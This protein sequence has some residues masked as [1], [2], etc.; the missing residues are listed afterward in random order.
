MKQ[1]HS[2]IP[3]VEVNA[4][5]SILGFLAASSVQTP[6]PSSKHRW[7]LVYTILCC[8]TGVLPKVLEGHEKTK[9]CS[10]HIARCEIE[11]GYLHLLVSRGALMP[12]DGTDKIIETILKRLILLQ[13]NSI[14]DDMYFCRSHEVSFSEDK[15]LDEWESSSLRHKSADAAPIPVVLDRHFLLPELL[16]NGVEL[17]VSWTSQTRRKPVLWTQLALSISKLQELGNAYPSSKVADLTFAELFQHDER[18]GALFVREAAGAFLTAFDIVRSEFAIAAK[19]PYI[20]RAAMSRTW[21]LLSDSDMKLRHE[22]LN[23]KNVHGQTTYR[24]ENPCTLCFS[25]IRSFCMYSFAHVGK[26]ITFVD[27]G[28]GAIAPHDG[29]QNSMGVTHQYL[30]H[31][32]LSYIFVSLDHMS[33]Y[34]LAKRVGNSNAESLVMALSLSFTWLNQIAGICKEK[35]GGDNTQLL[36][37]EL[38]SEL[39]MVG[40]TILN[41]C[42][43]TLGKCMFAV[44]WLS[45]CNGADTCFRLCT[46]TIRNV[47]AWAV[48]ARVDDRLTSDTG[49]FDHLDDTAFFCMED[50]GETPADVLSQI[51]VKLLKNADPS[52]LYSVDRDFSLDDTVPALDSHGRN[53]LY[54]CSGRLCACL[55]SLVAAGSKCDFKESVVRSAFGRPEIDT[56]KRYLTFV[57][58]TESCTLADRFSQCK[59]FLEQAYDTFVMTL[60]DMVL[61]ADS[62]VRFPTCDIEIMMNMTGNKGARRERKRL[63]RVNGKHVANRGFGVQKGEEI[64]EIGPVYVCRNLWTCLQDF[65]KVFSVRASA[66][67]LA[68]QLEATEHEADIECNFHDSLEMECLR[69]MKFLLSFFRVDAVANVEGAFED[70]LV[71]AVKS[72]ML[73]LLTIAEGLLYHDLKRQKSTTESQAALSPAHCKL[74]ILQSSYVEMFVGTV[75]KVVLANWYKFSDSVRCLLSSLREVLVFSMSNGIDSDIEGCFRQLVGRPERRDLCHRFSAPMLDL[76]KCVKLACL[77]RSRE[78][79]R[80]HLALAPTADRQ[81]GAIALVASASSFVSNA[82]IPCDYVLDVISEGFRIKS[83]SSVSSASGRPIF[84]DYVDEHIFRAKEAPRAAGAGEETL[85]DNRIRILRMFALSKVI[86]SRL[87][88]RTQTTQGAKALLVGLANRLL[89]IEIDEMGRSTGIKAESALELHDLLNSLWV[90]IRESVKFGPESCTL[91]SSTLRC[92]SLIMTLPIIGINGQTMQSMLRWSRLSTN[93]TLYHGCTLPDTTS[94]ETFACC[95]STL[96]ALAF[97]VSSFLCQ[98]SSRSSIHVARILEKA[99]GETGEDVLH[100]TVPSLDAFAIESLVSQ[101]GIVN[102][103]IDCKNKNNGDVPRN[104]YVKHANV[105]GGRSLLA[106]LEQVSPEVK[107]EAANLKAII[108]VCYENEK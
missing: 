29:N 3:R 74:L 59:A 31:E 53:L 55:A 80:H 105:M 20:S 70:I 72:S 107:R 24:N 15:V 5:W 87:R 84:Q 36:R 23:G 91:L 43:K 52:K 62:L 33:S 95:L 12:L 69:R 16:Q 51:I 50:E 106:A 26:P 66:S 85:L 88:S 71:L 89:Y 45:Q 4:I 77:R 37:G 78:V 108:E 104:I 56:Y 57:L 61:D 90:V 41:L 13:A 60:L 2:K 22:G 10:Q 21:C 9:P 73:N 75:C 76:R 68:C 102:K 35:L 96:A 39:R 101:L 46:T 48:I 49:E 100:L 27:G 6:A 54:R 11:L 98:P 25:A 65:R 34:I 97:H 67:P 19:K 99:D 30:L 18:H 63:H 79:I 32:A 86:P 47:V 8:E 103:A 81:R 7:L 44:L 14:R 94:L 92:L 40:S 42:A 58:L 64:D 38:R 28:A 83:E 1:F 93:Q 17:L 82:T